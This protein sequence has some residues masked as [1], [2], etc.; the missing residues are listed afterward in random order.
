ME[1]LTVILFLIQILLLCIVV[2][3]NKKNSRNEDLEQIKTKMDALTK[4][5]V[6]MRTTIL[7]LEK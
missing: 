2:Y 5:V 4:A 6:K 1:F 7:T 3:N